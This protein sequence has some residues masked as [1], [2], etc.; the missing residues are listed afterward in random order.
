MKIT[1]IN[2]REDFGWTQWSKSMLSSFF[3]WLSV[4]FKNTVV[5]EDLWNRIGLIFFNS[6]HFIPSSIHRCLKKPTNNF[7]SPYL[8]FKQL[9]IYKKIQWLYSTHMFSVTNMLTQRYI[10][11][12]IELKLTQMSLFY[13]LNSL[14][15]FRIPKCPS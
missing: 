15:V 6:H 3:K 14:E 4:L 2:K 5:S 1:Q 9:N 8:I 12:E 7:P 11:D 13:N 10:R